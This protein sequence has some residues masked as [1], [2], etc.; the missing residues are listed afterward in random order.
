MGL[1]FGKRCPFEFSGY[2]PESHT[3]WEGFVF[4]TERTEKPI[5]PFYCGARAID[6]LQRSIVME[7]TRIHSFQQ[8]AFE[9]AA[10]SRSGRIDGAS[11]SLQGAARL[12]ET[13]F[14]YRQAEANEKLRIVLRLQ[15]YVPEQDSVAAQPAGQAKAICGR[16][17]IL[18][19]LTQIL[20]HN[21]TAITAAS[22]IL[23]QPNAMKVCVCT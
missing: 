18:V 7:C 22:T 17:T 6:G 1:G 2:S 11:A 9:F 13:Q 20:N 23:Y 12:I 19:S 21:K 4:L 8:Q 15:F 16:V 5:D 10:V 14:L 3:E